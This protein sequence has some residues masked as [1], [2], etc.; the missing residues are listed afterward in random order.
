[1]TL[2]CD[3]K[4]L[5]DDFNQVDI[6]HVIQPS[7]PLRRR[8]RFCRQNTIFSY[9][10]DILISTSHLFKFPQNGANCDD[11]ATSSVFAFANGDI[12]SGLL[13]K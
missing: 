1:M 6:K 10:S 2:L 5:T 8:K 4:I 7:V 11:D 9:I 13:Y 12:C 3:D